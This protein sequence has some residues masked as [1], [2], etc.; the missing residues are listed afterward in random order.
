MARALRWV[1]FFVLAYLA[2]G[3][4]SGL[5]GVAQIGGGP[6]N[7]VLIAVAF[8]AINARQHAAVGGCFVL[9]L[10]HDLIGTG[11]LGGY[12]L[13][14]T[15]VAF[16]MAGTDRALNVE[17]AWTH[18]VVVFLGGIVTA[19]VL[20]LQGRVG[21]Y[22]QPIPLWPNVAGAFYTSVLAIFVLRGLTKLRKRFRFKGS[23]GR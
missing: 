18:F 16:L 20:W 22:G 6:L 11:P 12:A 7:V 5:G 13:A 4:Q 17:H 3:L 15:L 8:I 10:L 2:L 9:G 1:P 14:Y 21:V 19:I 23:I